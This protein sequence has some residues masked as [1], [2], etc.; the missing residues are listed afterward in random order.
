MTNSSRNFVK[1]LKEICKENHFPIK[2]YGVD[3]VFEIKKPNN[4]LF[5]IVGY[6]F[7]DN[8]SSK[9]ICDDKSSL[10]EIL[11]THRICN[12]PHIYFM[13]PSDNFYIG[14][15]N[16]KKR[17]LATFDQFQHNI[18][19]KPNSGTSGDN[20]FHIT[21]KDI[22]LKKANLLFKQNRHIA[23]CPF[24]N[25]TNEFRVIVYKNKPQLIFDKQ[26]TNSWKHNL[27]HGSIPVNVNNKNLISKISKLAISATSLLNIK[28]ASVDIAMVKDELMILEINS[29]VMLEKFSCFSKQNYEKAKSIYK[30][31]IL[32]L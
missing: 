10:S 30:K 27:A 4:K 25:I 19:M 2:S 9:K 17:L 7:P 18:V 14:E 5:Y 1:I 11:T 16:W 12:I 8:S 31:V 21:N 23:I 32:D 22:L 24:L 28:F 29:G 26:R 6:E 20:V 3:W 13:N 15:T